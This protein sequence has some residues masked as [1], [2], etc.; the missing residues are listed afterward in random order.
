MCLTQRILFRDENLL[1]CL[2][3]MIRVDTQVDDK[4]IRH[5]SRLMTKFSLEDYGISNPDLNLPYLKS[6]KEVK[7][8]L[9][10]TK[11]APIDKLV[12]TMEVMSLIKREINDRAQSKI[13][14]ERSD[15]IS[16]LQYVVV[17]SQVGD[18]R[19]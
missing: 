5:K 14:L 1:K 12:G 3:I 10:S 19:A 16:L 17:Q 7:S 8:V 9:G 6:V 11:F 18:L 13:D 2:I 4:D 15:L